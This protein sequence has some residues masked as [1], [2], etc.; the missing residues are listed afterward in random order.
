[1]LKIISQGK[2]FTDKRKCEAVS[3]EHLLLEI[4]FCYIFKENHK[5]HQNNNNNNPEQL[6]HNNNN[7][8]DSD[9]KR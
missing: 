8:D 2:N 6:I 5:L 7:G 1:M 9:N 4:I 3:F